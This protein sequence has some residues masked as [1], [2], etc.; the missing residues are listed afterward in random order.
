[1]KK[2]RVHGPSLRV[3]S[4]ASLYKD[5]E[6]WSRVQKSFVK[7]FFSD[8]MVLL[9]FN[10]NYCVMFEFWDAMKSYMSPFGATFVEKCI[11]L[12]SSFFR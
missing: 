2:S 6:G 3:P 7:K 4:L 10:E 11:S 5:F 9:A 12:V 8:G 1:M